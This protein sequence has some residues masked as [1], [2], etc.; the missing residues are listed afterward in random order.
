MFGEQVWWT[1]TDH[2]YKFFDSDFDDE[3]KSVGPSLM[4]F[5]SHTWLLKRHTDSWKTII[6]NESITLPSPFIKLYDEDDY[7]INTRSYSGCHCSQQPHTSATEKV[8]SV[9]LH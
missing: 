2:E 7:L 3:H 8:T 5:N 9:E 4:H 1:E 6:E